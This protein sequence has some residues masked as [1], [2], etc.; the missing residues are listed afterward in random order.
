MYNIIYYTYTLFLIL[1]VF[2]ENNNRNNIDLKKIKLVGFDI[3]KEVFE[4][5]TEFD[6]KKCKLVN[7]LN[8]SIKFGWD[9]E[10][11]SL[12]LRLEIFI[13]RKVDKSDC[14]NSV[15]SHL[16]LV[17]INLFEHQEID[18]FIKEIENREFDDKENLYEVTNY[19]LKLSY[20]K[21]REHIEYIFK[22]SNM[23]IKLPEN[24]K[25]GD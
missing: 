24:L 20:P 9:N 7:E 19:L 2:M 3:I 21:V 25:V 6:F 22:R 18:E 4:K 13:T 16:E 8:V 11:H 17:V 14:E 15:Q 23:K 12:A 1:G 10:K 5:N